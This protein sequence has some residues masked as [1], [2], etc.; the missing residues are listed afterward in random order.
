METIGVDRLFAS[1]IVSGVIPF[2]FLP[3]LTFIIAMLMAMATGVRIIICSVT[4]LWVF[5]S[6][7]GATTPFCSRECTYILT[8]VS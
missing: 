8:H 5:K 6:I 3:M 4:L 2:Q 7:D 1:I